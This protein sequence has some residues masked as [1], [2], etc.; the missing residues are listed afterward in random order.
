MVI[1]QINNIEKSNMQF[2]SLNP[3]YCEKIT[4][5]LKSKCK[6]NY[7]ECES[8]KKN[9]LIQPFS[10]ILCI[11]KGSIRAGHVNIEVSSLRS[12]KLWRH[13]VC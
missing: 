2:Y 6:I 8:T 7:T 3:Y 1:L 11:Y 13:L 10:A 12:Y 4:N 5:R 9:L